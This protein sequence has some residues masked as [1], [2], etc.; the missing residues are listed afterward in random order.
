MQLEQER[1]EAEKMRVRQT[2]HSVRNAVAVNLGV[3]CSVETK[4]FSCSLALLSLVWK[5]TKVE[6]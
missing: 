3:L 2:L 4:L 5:K 1:I 6:S